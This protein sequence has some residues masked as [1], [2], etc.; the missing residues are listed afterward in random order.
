MPEIVLT[1][2]TPFSHLCSSRP[3]GNTLAATDMNSMFL[4]SEFDQPLDHF[5]TDLVTDMKFMSE[6]VLPMN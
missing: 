5:I 3:A 1:N 6:F 2:Q 4:F